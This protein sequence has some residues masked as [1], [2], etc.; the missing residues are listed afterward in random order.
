[1]DDAHAQPVEKILR[2]SG[3]PLESGLTQPEVAKRR[4]KYGLNRLSETARRGVWTILLGQ[5]RGIIIYLLAAAAALSF[6]LGDWAEG[7]TIVAV[8]AINSTIGFT[9]ELRA[10]K[11]ME[12]L[13]RL[14]RVHARVRREGRTVTV[15]ADEI[16]PGDIILLQSGDVVPADLRLVNSAGL[17]C[18]ESAL[19][20]ESLP[21]SKSVGRVSSDAPVAERTSMAFKGTAVTRGTG[22]AISVATGM[23]T[24][25]GKI[26]TLAAEAKAEISPL[27]KRL[28][29]LGGQLVWATLGLAVL[30]GVSGVYA[31]HPFATMVKTA[32]ALAVAA[33]P[34]GL[35]I[36]ATVALARGMWRMARRNALIENLSAVETLGATT[37]VL[38]DKTGTLTE[39]RMTVDR[40]RVVDG[41]VQLDSKAGGVH[42]TD[43]LSDQ[44][45]AAN[46]PARL[47]LRIAALCNN[48]SLATPDNQGRTERDEGDPMEIALLAAGRR[49]RMEAG[50]LE[51]EFPRVAEEPFSPETRMMATIHQP[52][53]RPGT[54]MNYFVA[55]KGAPEEVIRHSV[56]LFAG[57]GAVPLDDAGRTDW[58]RY[59][60][61][62][63]LKG[64]RVL[65]VA[66]KE[67]SQPNVMPYDDLT[68]VGLV[69][70]LDPPRADVGA[71]IEACHSAG[72]RVVMI[73]GDHAGTAL[74]IAQ[75]INLAGDDAS[76]IDTADIRA[77]EVIP[78][79]EEARFLQALVFARV[80]PETKLSIVSLY[81]RNGEIVAMTGDG[82]ND[83]PAL[84]KADI[85]VAMGQRGTEVAREAADMVLRDDAFP[86]IVAAMRQGRVIFG[87][88]RKFVVYLMSCNL[89]EILVIG[90]AAMS[91]LPLPLLPLQILYLNLVTDVF[92]AFALG[93][94]EGDPHIMRR[95]PRDPREAILGRDRWIAIVV[96]G[97]FITSAVIANFVLALGPLGMGEQQALT[98]SFL[99]LAFAQLWH[100]FNMRASDAP[101]LRNE[102][103]ENPFVW[104]A[105]ALSAALITGAVAVPG[106]ADLLGM[107]MP[108]FRGWCLAI[109]GSLVPLALGLGLH[110]LRPNWLRRMQ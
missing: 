88:I 78:P 8:L 105:L 53:A 109:G 75:N 99:T 25:I 21:V 43:A 14:S 76:V 22:I 38:T 83:A 79:A 73:T 55:V 49:A 19:T 108:D 42:P 23:E 16:V 92:P 77:G 36:V 106:L 31:G 89:S 34:E 66:M 48:A 45:K 64:L 6:F 101:L 110:V 68:L 72:V 104:G 12:S 20:G 59:N 29:R 32:V 97:V 94:G 56:R 63:T 39:N 1:M 5:F 15:L 24:E 81:Q 33:V 82:V 58:L 69:G 2:M 67:A 80:S 74:T 47:A 26:A 91:G 107:A 40:I 60:D 52:P 10:I 28:D 93:F 86:S 41:I 30:I 4:R 3:V 27:E 84:K 90:G 46:G 102:V 44:G 61:D 13:R 95:P 57:E 85:G 65:A 37:V 17:Q 62:M 103:T 11:S 96:Y 9:T 50:S 51:A 87:N 100:V 35:P 70:L 98:I 54:D 7:W 18:D 71:A